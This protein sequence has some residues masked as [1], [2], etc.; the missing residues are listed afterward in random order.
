MTKLVLVVM[1]V[2]C[3]GAAA[4]AP[5]AAPAKKFA[6]RTYTFVLL[7]RGPAWTPEETDET[8]RLFDGHMAN[9]VA[10]HA[11]GKLVLAGPLEDPTNPQDSY[12]GLFVL[13][14]ASDAEAHAL[15][16]KDPAIAAGRLVAELRRWYGPVGITYAGADSIAP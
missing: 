8:K 6:M 3:G 4:S 10:M 7:R 9:I 13:D 15:L 16:A 14:V 2:A 1:L 11:A 12:A 5:P